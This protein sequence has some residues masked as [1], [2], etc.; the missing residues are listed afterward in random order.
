MIKLFILI[1][2]CAMALAGCGGNYYYEDGL[3]YF[4]GRQY[5][6][7]IGDL[8]LAVREDPLNKE[9]HHK[10]AESYFRT[11]RTG[12][13]V[14]QYK[15]IL[16]I[17]SDDQRA[18]KQL[19]RIIADMN[20]KAIKLNEE[21]KYN[22][23]YN[24]FKKVLDINIENKTA[25]QAI[26]DMASIFIERG[27]EYYKKGKEG[28]DEKDYLVAAASYTRAMD[29]N[30]SLRENV[31]EKLA[32][33]RDIYQFEAEKIR[34]ADAYA[35][36]DAYEQALIADP[37]NSELHFKI[38]KLY[39]FFTDFK[40]DALSSFT[41]AAALDPYTSRYHAY[42][43]ELHYLRSNYKLAEKEYLRSFKLLKEEIKNKKYNKQR[44]KYFYDSIEPYARIVVE[45]EQEEKKEEKEQEE[46]EELEEGI[47]LI[48]KKDKKVKIELD[49]KNVLAYRR[50]L[51]IFN[52]FPKLYPILKKGKLEESEKLEIAKNIQ[53][54]DDLIQKDEEDREKETEIYKAILK[55]FRGIDSNAVEKA[56]K[57]GKLI[58]DF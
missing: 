12:D 56:E 52:L 24:I 16:V 48:L 22:E 10:L 55:G 37:F 3:Y 17:D 36:I 39:G 11:G 31:K 26:S 18:E 4:E 25:R 50:A 45:I 29:I 5:D 54:L 49:E 33:I 34:R 51:D 47:Y 9:I 21:K 44:F 42:L 46:K 28:E 43:G 19:N 38:G 27:D 13:A 6:K 1:I 53:L 57:L 20:K 40:E 30:P 2:C 8:R 58:L 23:A 35:A 32:E 7:A 14:K 15:T 41:K